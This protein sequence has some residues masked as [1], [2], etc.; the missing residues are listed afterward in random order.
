MK[1]SAD[2]LFGRLL[3]TFL[4][5]RSNNTFIQMFRYGLVACVALFVD[6]TTLYLLTSGAG[7]HYLLSAAIAF[8]L[9]LATN[10]L[11]SVRWVFAA[12]RV[13][14][15]NLEFLIF[16]VI[17]LFGLGLTELLMWL[18]TQK[19]GLHYLGSKMVATV[20][21]FFWNFLVRKYTLFDKQAKK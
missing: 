21:V 7:F 15:R 13:A 4:I 9:G 10:F 14:D 19:A 20:I 5:D 12:R 17:G 1:P 2:S 8:M 6:F 11:L 16:G 18:L 3:G